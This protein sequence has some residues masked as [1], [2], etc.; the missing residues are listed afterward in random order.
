VHFQ[1]SEEKAPAPYDSRHLL[2]EDD[3]HRRDKRLHQEV[4]P[5]ELFHKA[6][7]S[8]VQVRSQL[9]EVWCVSNK[10]KN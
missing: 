8:A 4:L 1:Q 6:L 5:A 7:C 9:D 2:E 3:M 10:V